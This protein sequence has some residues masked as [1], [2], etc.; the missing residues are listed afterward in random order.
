MVKKLNPSFV[1]YFAAYLK[2]LLGIKKNGGVINAEMFQGKVTAAANDYLN[3]NYGID[4]GGVRSAIAQSTPEAEC[5]NAIK[6]RVHHNIQPDPRIS[7]YKTQTEIGK[8]TL[9]D[10]TATL[11]KA[12]NDHKKVD[13]STSSTN[14]S[15]PDMREGKDGKKKQTIVEFTP[16]SAVYCGKCWI[17]N[18]DVMSYSGNS[19][20]MYDAD[21][22]LMPEGSTGG[23]YIPC[24]TPCGDCEHVSAIMASYIA[25]MLKSGGFAKFY[26]ASYY[27]A[28]VECNR[29]K[30][31]YIGV[32]LHSTKGWEVDED[33]VNAIV[34]AIFPEGGVD[35]HASEY[36]PI[37]NALTVSYNSMT[38]DEKNEFRADVHENIKLGT[39]IWCI[40]ANEQM[41]KSSAS[42]KMAFNVS[43]I[44]VAITGHLEVITKKL[45]KKASKSK[46]VYKS[47]TPWSK[48]RIGGMP[49]S[50]DDD[51][52]YDIT[53]DM[54]VDDYILRWH[55][56]NVVEHVDEMDKED[57]E[58]KDEV[59]DDEKG[60]DEMDT[61][62]DEQE[63]IALI[64][65]FIDEFY[66]A[67]YSKEFGEK[68]FEQFDIDPVIFEMLMTRLS[69]SMEEIIISLHDIQLA[70]VVSGSAEST[71]MLSQAVGPYVYKFGPGAKVGS[72]SQ[73]SEY[74]EYS[75]YAADSDAK[76]VSQNPDDIVK[77]KTT[78]V[79]GPQQ[80]AAVVTLTKNASETDD[81]AGQTSK[82]AKIDPTSLGTIP[83]VELEKEE[84]GSRLNK[85]HSKNKSQ[86]HNQM[87]RTKRISYIKHKQTRKNQHSRKTK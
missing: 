15:L 16:S 67:P 87:N 27:V 54:T 32:K 39:Q 49:T 68:L 82:M 45:Q 1:Q 42:S 72:A 17:C 8:V 61:E 73:D 10:S 23:F 85:N 59:K 9:E 55:K 13:F 7:Y 28:C 50:N 25:G 74:S 43:R 66:K 75:Q 6:A 11:T 18:S 37:R 34:N 47:S 4:A 29:R 38:D 63:N 51:D 12:I 26:W 21:E 52:D 41:T 83:L 58:G 78:P 3:E 69:H 80:Q 14:I 57:E 53:D 40:T 31:N 48:R 60:K 64:E 86:T 19:K 71:P 77:L 36:N 30:S 76:M 2:D 81:Y 65:T 70:H 84:G 20:R 35:Q 22:K 56:L 5:A 33:G 24:T 44:I 62:D 79:K 46:T